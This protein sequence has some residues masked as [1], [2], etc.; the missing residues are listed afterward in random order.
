MKILATA[1]RV[2]DPDSIIEVKPDGSSIDLPGI[3]FTIN[4]F[5]EIAVE[6]GVRIRE[7]HGGEVTVVS[8]GSEDCQSEIRKAFAMGADRGIL[9]TAHE[10]LDSDAVARILAKIVE[11]EQ[12]DII[13]MGKQAID[14]DDIQVAQLLAEYTGLG[15]ACFATRIELTGNK[16]LVDREVDGGIEVVEVML[17]CVISAELRLN[18]PR[19]IPLPAIVEAN[20]KQ[21]E[22]SIVSALGIDTA[23]KVIVQNLEV[24]AE[25]KE[26]HMLE[27]VSDLLEIFKK[28]GIIEQA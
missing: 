2:T 16:V 25:R 15:Q 21:I 11:K 13:L 8:I 27:T 19:N 12:P 4:P 7:A 5:D 6:E 18:E 1:K 24:P 20:K 9:I 14:L 10:E 17:P 23:P 22:M 26:C 28:N 3:Q